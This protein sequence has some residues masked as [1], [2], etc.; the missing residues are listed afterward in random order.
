MAFTKGRRPAREERERPA[1][2]LAQHKGPGERG[3]RP[4]EEGGRRGE[5]PSDCCPSR[6]SRPLGRAHHTPL[7]PP[8]APTIRLESD[9]PLAPSPSHTFRCGRSRTFGPSGSRPPRPRAVR[10]RSPSSFWARS[11]P[12]LPALSQGLHAGSGLGGLALAAGEGVGGMRGAGW[13]DSHWLQVRG[14]AHN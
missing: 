4:V 5:R 12:V 1:G 6:V 10:T 9:T 2:G 13:E 7:S 8:T 3:L 14:L 11:T